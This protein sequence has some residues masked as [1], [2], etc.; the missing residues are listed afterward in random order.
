[1]LTPMEEAITRA[2][3]IAAGL[4]LS[5]MILDLIKR[6]E[7]Q[8]KAYLDR[9]ASKEDRAAALRES[10]SINTT[11]SIVAMQQSMLGIGA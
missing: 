4:A 10:R 5:G 7:C 1:M 2:Q 3:E 6:G 8:R 11:L 9:D